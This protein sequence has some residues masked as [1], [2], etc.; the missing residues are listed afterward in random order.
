MIANSFHN[1]KQMDPYI[2]INRKR[3]MELLL[4]NERDLRM[5]VTQTQT[6]GNLIY[7]GNH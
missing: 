4:K 1:L 6:L 2:T 7:F 5:K 3:K